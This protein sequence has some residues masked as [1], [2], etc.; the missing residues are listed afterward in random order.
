MARQT[1][2]VIRPIPGMVGLKSGDLVDASEWR[3]AAKLVRTR[4]LRPL[5][6]VA[7]LKARIAELEAEVAEL[8]RPKAAAGRR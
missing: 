1:H 6:N 8:T 4:Y 5:D 7:A 3:A 2:E